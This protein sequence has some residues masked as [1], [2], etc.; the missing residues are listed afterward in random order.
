MTH[1][2]TRPTLRD[3][4][5]CHAKG[6]DEETVFFST[7]TVILSDGDSYDSHYMILCIGCGVELNDDSR[8]DLVDRWNGVVRTTE[9]FSASDEVAA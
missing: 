6:S 9:E 1:K 8:D 3:C 2:E 5:F 4:P 7:N